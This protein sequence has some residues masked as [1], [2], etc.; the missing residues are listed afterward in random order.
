MEST[1]ILDRVKTGGDMPHGWIVFPLSRRKVAIGILGWIFGV[2]VGLGLF[3]VIA[4]LTI[5]HNYQQGAAAIIFTTILLG[6]MLYVGLGS[7]WALIMDARR[8]SQADKHVIVITPEDFVKQ[9][10]SRII[11]VPLMYVRH[12]TARGGRPPQP[13]RTTTSNPI[14]EMPGFG[15]QLGSMFFGRRNVATGSEGARRKRMR[16]PTTLAFVDDRNQSEVIVV[17]DA[18]YGDPYIIAALLKQYAASVQQLA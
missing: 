4:W 17:T 9:D 5:P 15:E 14:R 13:E 8:L 12:V 1:E 7:I 18:A 11:H 3:A 6:I 16:T 10:G 2:I